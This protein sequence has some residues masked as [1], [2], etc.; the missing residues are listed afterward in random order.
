MRGI[1]PYPRPFPAGLRTLAAA[2]T[3]LALGACGQT[4]SRPNVLLIT[5][6]TLRPDAL[7]WIAGA[8]DTP[9]ID[10]IARGS[11]RFRTALTPVPL[12]LPAHV[13]LMTGQLPHRHG[14]R[15]NGQVLAAGPATLA[16][17]L[18]AD[19][20]ATGAFVS[21][22]PLRALF[23]LD[24]GFDHYDDV[25]PGGSEGWVE[26]PAADTTGAALAW[27]GAA[28]PPWFAWIH[29]YDP[30]DPYTPHETFPRRGPRAA[31]DSEVAYVDHAVGTL[32]A[33]LP[34]G[35]LLTV[36]TADH[37]ESFGEHG[38]FLHGFFVYDTTMVVPLLVHFPGRVAPADR[39]AMVGLVDVVPT[40]H[41]LLGLPAARDVDGASLVPALVND[42]PPADVV[43]LETLQPWLTFGWSPLRA[44]RT[45][46][47]KLID[48]PHP[49]LYDLRRDPEETRNVIDQHADEAARLRTGLAPL[50]SDRGT[51]AERIGDPAVQARLEA[52]GYLTVA[53]AAAPPGGLP[54]PKDRLGQRRTLLEAEGLLRRGA[55]GE[56]VA[57]FDAVLAHDPG[58]R[59][60]I[61]R[62]G[63][64]LLKTGDPQGAVPR[65][66]RAVAIAPDVAEAHYALADALTRTRRWDAAIAE[67]QETTRLQPRRVAAW[68]N[69]GTVLGL[70]GRLP[71]ARGA[72]EHAVTL[73]PEDARLLVNLALVERRIDD[74]PAAA[75]HLAEAA[76]RLPPAE[77]GFAATLG[78]VLARLGRHDEA[79]VWLARAKAGEAEF[80]PARFELARQ[81]AAAGDPTG[82]SRALGEALAAAPDLRERAARDPRLGPLLR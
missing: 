78:L 31:Y 20:Y 53:S 3:A 55:F 45:A 24:R 70:V 44:V 1:A 13:S 39:E 33:A 71:E 58:N 12:T 4:S 57:R 42:A 66:Q 46:R 38:E 52:L 74:D 69:L 82:A 18:R 72:L 61:L 50:A 43:Q 11:A 77:I 73:A 2:V 47:W 37:G 81:L 75:R 54:D 48:A 64:A 5:I 7:G 16:E 28:A 62:S 14:V 56:A 80:G 15:D 6:D 27:I 59:F 30:H 23:G 36:L 32:L 51:M 34:R 79:R 29:Y 35:P 63:M 10:A 17:T 41:E 22:Y 60:A 19:G 65:L 68:S 49:E 21:G 25:L 40:I 26:R 67:W 9:A 76:Q 8:N